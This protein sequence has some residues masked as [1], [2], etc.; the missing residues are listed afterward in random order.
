MTL[1][2]LQYFISLAK[3]LH[4]TR[5]S[6]QLHISQPSL[7]Y[8]IRE[9]ERSLGVELFHR[10]RRQISLTEQGK[11]F[12]PYAE[13]AIST[14]DKGTELLRRM[15]KTS[16]GEIRLGYFH[17]VATPF[18]PDLVDGYYEAFGKEARFRFTEGNSR[19]ICALLQKGELDLCFTPEPGG[20]RFRRGYPS[21]PLL[22]HE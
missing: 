8:E 11:A 15:E 7:S 20:L 18:V 6:E 16:L 13:K 10:T 17:S 22:L 4:Y 12:L 9:L 19:E 2:Q 21:A 14:L 3:T 5:T 1:L